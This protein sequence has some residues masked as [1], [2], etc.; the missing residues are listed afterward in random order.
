MIRNPIFRRSDDSH[1]RLYHIEIVYIPPQSLANEE[2]SPV[3][4]EV[5]R[6]ILVPLSKQSYENYQL[7]QN[8]ISSPE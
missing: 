1:H 6:D 4:A 7:T 2:L 5:E 3:L 8:S